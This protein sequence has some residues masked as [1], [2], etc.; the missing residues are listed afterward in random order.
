MSAIVPL[1]LF[2]SSLFYINKYSFRNYVDIVLS[3]LFG[4]GSHFEFDAI[5]VM[6]LL[7][8]MMERGYNAAVRRGYAHNSV[9]ETVAVYQSISSFFSLF[10]SN[11]FSFFFSK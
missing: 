5:C 6:S 2:Q 8:R 4:F 3:Y 7:F 10:I 1:I 9:Q 11:I